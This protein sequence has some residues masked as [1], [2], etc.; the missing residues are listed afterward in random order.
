MRYHLITENDLESM[1]VVR[2]YH[3]WWL[4]AYV[5]AWLFVRRHPCGAATVQSAED[6]PVARVQR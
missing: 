5:A 2:S 4:A 1:P 3:R 6:L